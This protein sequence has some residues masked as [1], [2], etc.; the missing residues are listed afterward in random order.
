MKQKRLRYR[1]V[2]KGTCRERLGL[3]VT[4][5]NHQHPNCQCGERLSSPT[6]VS[7]DFVPTRAASPHE[8]A[9]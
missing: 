7:R 8:A 1:V 5:N 3:R 6:W 4:A 2:Q 9:F